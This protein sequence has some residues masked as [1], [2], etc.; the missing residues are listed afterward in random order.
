MPNNKQILFELLKR[1][2]GVTYEQFCEVASVGKQC[3]HG[4]ITNLR[5]KE[6]LDVVRE[7][8]VYS[9]NPDAKL[10]PRKNAKKKPEGHRT[11]CGITKCPVDGSILRLTARPTVCFECFKQGRV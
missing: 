2:E 8:Y 6:D 5:I 9:T 3:F 11:F 10:K 7:G 4:M 1:P